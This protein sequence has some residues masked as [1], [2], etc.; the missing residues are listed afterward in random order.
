MFF[1]PRIS[2]ISPEEAK[3]LVGRGA[4][5]IDVR[6]PREFERG[7]PRGAANVP[8]ADLD[9]AVASLEGDEVVCI[10]AMGPRSKQATKALTKAGIKAH[11]VSGGA[12]AWRRAG[13]PWQ[14]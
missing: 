10:C 2:N 11:N 6:S 13:L 7:H 5:F 9:G 14:P 3:R 8:L 4:R 1:G 12:V